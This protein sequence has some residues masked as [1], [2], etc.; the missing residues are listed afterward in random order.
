MLRTDEL[1]S[2][3][4]YLRECEAAVVEATAEG[5]V[6]DETVFYSRGEDSPVTSACSGGTAGRSKWSTR[7]VET[8]F[9]STSSMASR[10]QRGR[11]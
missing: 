3:D 8:A 4:A 5:V 6:L 7:F 2:T 1:C 11:R 10:L 9:R